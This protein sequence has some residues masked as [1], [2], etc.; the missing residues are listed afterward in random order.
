MSYDL[1][2]TSPKISRNQFQSYFSER[3][4]YEVTE[5]QVWYQNE[6][7]GVYFSFDFNDTPSEDED[8]VEYSVAFN[9]NFFRP[10]FF[11]LEAEPEVTQFVERFG[12]QIHDPQN[13]GM[14]DGPYTPEGFLKGWNHGNE[15]GCSAIL[16]QE[17]DVGKIFTKPKDELERIW[18]WNYQKE[19]LQE[20]LKKDI[21]VPGIMFMEIDSTVSSVV[22]W[23]DAISTLIPQVDCLF[24]VRDELAPKRLFGKKQDECIIPLIEAKTVLE[25]YS[26]TDYSIPSFQLPAPDTP[27]EL[28]DFVRSLK[29]SKQKIEGIG[30]D[31]VLDMELVEKH[32]KV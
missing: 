23:P 3:P 10:H 31:Q 24:I 5:D 28:K 26:T 8:E 16:N 32:R 19:E 15:F 9:M 17:Q 12:C 14:E 7:T 20:N 2:F 29:P 11:A 6:C 30:A 1:Y 18:R 13:D 27:S 22:V 25:S 21:F 4:L